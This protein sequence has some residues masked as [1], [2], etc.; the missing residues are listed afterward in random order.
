MVLSLFCS[1][2]RA[3]EYVLKECRWSQP[4]ASHQAYLYQAAVSAFLTPDACFTL[5][6]E[7]QKALTLMS[8]CKVALANAT[9]DTCLQ[10][11]I[12]A[13]RVQKRRLIVIPQPKSS[14]KPHGSA[15]F[16]AVIESI[17]TTQEAKCRTPQSQRRFHCYYEAALI[18]V[19]TAARST[20]QVRAAQ[21]LLRWLYIC[22]KDLQWGAL[23][24]AN[25]EFKPT[26]KPK[27]GLK[28]STK[29]LSHSL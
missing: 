7:S 4:S 19:A 8:L 21:P 12:V 11:Q 27:R 14:I 10:E 29:C 20:Q 6:G 24:Y 25:G 1:R 26:V 2:C 3:L 17:R 13:T 18:S 5:K 9:I 28:L 16:N 23:I 22:V 15:A